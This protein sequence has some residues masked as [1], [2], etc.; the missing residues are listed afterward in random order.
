MTEPKQHM[1]PDCG[2][3]FL[4]VKQLELI[5]KRAQREPGE[6][7]GLCPACRR[8]RTGQKIKAAMR[9]AGALKT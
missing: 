4:T 2:E 1:C 7:F 5:K 3:P 6:E 8:R 9:A